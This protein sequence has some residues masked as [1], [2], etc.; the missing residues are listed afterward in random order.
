[1]RRI[2]RLVVTLLIG[3]YCAL[4][5][6]AAPG[7]MMGKVE[8]SG[9]ITDSQSL[10]DL[11]VKVVLPETYGLG[12]LDRFFGKPSDY[13]NTD[14]VGVVGV[15]E[16]GEFDIAFGPIVYHAAFWL[17]PPLG[18]QPKYPPDPFLAIGVSDSPDQVYLVQKK[19][20]KIVY[21]VWDVAAKTRIPIEK[22]SWRITDGSIEKTE[23]EY[24]EMKLNGKVMKLKIQRQASNPSMQPTADGGG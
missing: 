6:C 5:G 18:F 16:K 24:K 17:I 4:T 3:T 7:S 21:E 2:S 11:K 22:A 23:Y 9:M 8:L 10:Q 15:N 12:G 20:G 13:G 14:H 19:W 1:M